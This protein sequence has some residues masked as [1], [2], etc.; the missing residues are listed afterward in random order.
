M[1]FKQHKKILLEYLCTI[2]I[3]T[4]KKDVLKL[5]QSHK[6]T[7]GDVKNWK[8]QFRE[9]PNALKTQGSKYQEGKQPNSKE[10]SVGGGTNKYRLAT[11]KQFYTL[12]D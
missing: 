7:R 10:A 12:E 9:K 11:S 1:N 5:M 6:K 4:C 8:P 2:L 3:T